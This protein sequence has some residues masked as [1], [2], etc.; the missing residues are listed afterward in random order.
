MKDI[1]AYALSKG[2]TLTG[3]EGERMYAFPLSHVYYF[4]AV[5]ERCFA[6]TKQRVFE[7]RARLYALE[8]AYSGKFFVR[9]SKSALINLMLLES[10]SPAL[11]GRFTA[12]MKNGEKIIIS[13]QYAAEFKK[14]IMEG[15]RNAV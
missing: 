2:E 9:A 13:R 5:D 3:W 1:E 14:A 6:Y 15:V 4:E 12:L 7:V 8:E 11:N 10:I